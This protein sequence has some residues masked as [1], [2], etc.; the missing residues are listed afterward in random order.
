MANSKTITVC[1]AAASAA[2]VLCAALGNRVNAEDTTIAKLRA[3]D[4]RSFTDKEITSGFLKL[5]FNSEYPVSGRVDR[6]RKFD[7]PVRVFIE[8][9]ARAN[10]SEEIAAVVS[11]IAGRIQ[12]LD[13]AV[14]QNRREANLLTTLINDRDLPRVVRSLQ[15]RGRAQDT[16]RSLQPQC[17]SEIRRDKTFRIVRS[18]TILVADAGELV[19]Y[20][21]AYEELLQ[22]L[23][24]INDDPTVPWTMFNDEVQKGFF[25]IY[26]QFLLNILYDRRIRPGMTEAQ[27]RALLPEILPTVRAWVAKV[28]KSK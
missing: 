3:S 6:V 21:C 10:R 28:N 19:F 17:L 4:R 23:G 5:I 15:G 25:A 18:D 13:V 24:P 16:Q 7:G 20:D 8:N 2:I 9:R 11:D 1:R 26:D 14:T 12:N 22:A 27:V